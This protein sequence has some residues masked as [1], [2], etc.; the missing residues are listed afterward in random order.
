VEERRLQRRVGDPRHAGFSPS[1]LY[2]DSD[3]HRTLHHDRKERGFSRAVNAPR[4]IAA[5]A[6]SASPS[7][8]CSRIPGQE[9]PAEGG[10]T[11]GAILQPS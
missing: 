4:S 7:S 2:A 6:A 9:H 11:G 3:Q 10:S 8:T 1:G 5:L